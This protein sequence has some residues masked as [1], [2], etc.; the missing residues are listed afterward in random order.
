MRQDGQ[1]EWDREESA[2]GYLPTFRVE[3]REESGT[4]F[5]ETFNF[6]VMFFKF[7]QTTKTLWIRDVVGKVNR[8]SVISSKNETL[9]PKVQNAGSET[10]TNSRN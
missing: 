5:R 1:L 4:T 9:I 6:T 8:A 2:F 3:A 7:G 10:P